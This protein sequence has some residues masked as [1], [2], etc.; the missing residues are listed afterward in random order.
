MDLKMFYLLVT[1]ECSANPDLLPVLERFAK[2]QRLGWL[3]PKCGLPE[4]LLPA[5]PF[6]HSLNDGANTQHPFLVIGANSDHLADM[7]CN[8]PIIRVQLRSEQGAANLPDTLLIDDYSQ[9]NLLLEADAYPNMKSL[10]E[11]HG[12]NVKDFTQ[13]VFARYFKALDALKNGRRVVVFGAQR[14]GLEVAATLKSDGYDVV[15]FVDNATNKHGQYI[16]DIVILPLGDLKNK[17]IPI[18]IATTRYTSSI[19][20]QLHNEGFYNILPY[21]CLA[22]DNSH[23]LQDEIPYIGI[24]EDFSQNI[25]RYINTFIELEDDKSRRVLDGLVGYRLDYDSFKAEA[26]SDDSSTQYFDQELIKCDGADVFV[27]L[28]GYD[29]DTVEKFIDYSNGEYKKIY[30]FEPDINLLQKAKVRLADS[31]DIEFIEAGAYSEDGELRFSASGRTN[32]SISETGELKIS[33]RR[34]DTCLDCVPTFIKMD[35]EGAEAEAL[36]GAAKLIKAAKPKLAIV[37][38]HFAH[39]VWSLTN[40]IKNINPSYKFYLRHYSETGLESVIYAI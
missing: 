39:D 17:S 14:L 23:K 36:K 29:G 3:R 16:D 30:L 27:D 5:A 25:I 28:G 35:I 33:V 7:T 18:V 26:V 10:V 32:G 21:S 40:L 12:Y 13:R 4:L 34:L 19:T 8:R 11:C 2:A 15:A 22:L 37:C 9:L 38:Y 24:Q 1:N 6:H 20:R 31:R